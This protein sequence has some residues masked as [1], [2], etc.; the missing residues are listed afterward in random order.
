MTALPHQPGQQERLEA[1]AAQLVRNRVPL[2]AARLCFMW[3][4]IRMAQQEVGTLDKATR[5]VGTSPSRWSQ[6]C[7][8][9]AFHPLN[10]AGKQICWEMADHVFVDVCKSSHGWRLASWLFNRAMLRTAIRQAMQARFGS[11]PRRGDLQ[12][13]GE[14]LGIHRNSVR[15]LWNEEKPQ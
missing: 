14:L 10:E 13:A 5:K 12:A 3:Q 2:R 9:M 1:C 4:L 15:N 6:I 11:K 7:R 8:L